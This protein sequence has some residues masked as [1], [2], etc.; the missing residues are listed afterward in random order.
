[1]ALK[2]LTVS[3]G[4][5]L[6][7]GAPVFTMMWGLLLGIETFSVHLCLSLFVIAL[8]IAL[9][10]FGQ[11]TFV[12]T[13]FILQLLATALG[14]LRWAMTHGLL[15]GTR[16]GESSQRMAPLTATLY[17][18]PTTALCVLPVALLFEGSQVA[19]KMTTITANEFWIIFGSMLFVGTLVFILLM[20]EYWLVNATSSLALSVAGVFK[21]LLT[22]AGGITFF[23]DDLTLL[24]TIG[25]SICQAGIGAYMWLR[26][27]P[28]ETTRVNQVPV[29][30][31]PLTYNEASDGEGY[32]MGETDLQVMD[33]VPQPVLVTVRQ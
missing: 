27:D 5:I 25:F 30:E 24:N 3:F 2:I 20:S 11:H 4:T 12:L 9:A 22:I 1:M 19:T 23:K 14:G 28:D 16:D 18:S 8:G 26:Y 15:K 10:A 13:G 6:K 17:T 29:S 7:G 33:R 21:E 32:E 31:L